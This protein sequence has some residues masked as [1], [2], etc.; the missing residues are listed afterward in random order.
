MHPIF[1]DEGDGL[2]SQR[3]KGRECVRVLPSLMA[4]TIGYG[5]AVGAHNIV[6]VQIRMAGSTMFAWYRKQRCPQY[7]LCSDASERLYNVRLTWPG[8]TVL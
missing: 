1:I 8:G 5:M 2:T 3:W 6:Y 7:Y 4:H